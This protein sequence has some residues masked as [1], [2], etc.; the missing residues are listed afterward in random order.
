[1]SDFRRLAGCAHRLHGA[2]AVLIVT[3]GRFTGGRAL[4]ASKPDIHLADRRTLSA[5]AGGGRPLWEL[6]PN[7][8]G[9][10]R[11][12][13]DVIRLHSRRGRPS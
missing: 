2:D 12:G 1:M 10:P 7:I 5:W 3:N 9:A 13:G 11:G 6:L 4:P 8:D